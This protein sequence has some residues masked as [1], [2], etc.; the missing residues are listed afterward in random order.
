MEIKSRSAGRKSPQVNATEFQPSTQSQGKGSSQKQPECN[1]YGA[2][3]S[4][5]KVSCGSLVLFKYACRKYG[6]EEHIARK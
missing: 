5:P 6:R 4:H 3:P 2:T 1:Y